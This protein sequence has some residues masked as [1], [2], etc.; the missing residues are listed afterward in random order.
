MPRYGNMMK[1]FKKLNIHILCS[2]VCA[3]NQFDSINGGINTLH[4]NF[5]IEVFNNCKLQFIV[6]SKNTLTTIDFQLKL[7]SDGKKP[8][9]STLR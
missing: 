6:N 2:L 3:H 5:L 9:Y 7:D 4:N 8:R 1:N